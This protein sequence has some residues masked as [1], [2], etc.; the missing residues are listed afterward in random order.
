MDILVFFGALVVAMGFWVLQRLNDTFEMEVK[1]PLSLTG[2]P[3]GVTLTTPLP[4]SVQVTLRDRGTQLMNYM[5]HRIRP[6]TLEFS[7]YDD[8]GATGRGYVP[9]ADVQHAI[10]AQMLTSTVIQRI[11]P[12]T[13]EFFYNRGLHRR[14]PVRFLG[15]AEATERNYLHSITFSPDSVIVYAPALVL[16][17]MTHAYTEETHISNIEEDYVDNLRL[18]PMRGVKYEP[19]VVQMK[20]RVDYYTEKTVSVPIVG[21][22]FPADKVLRA[23]PAQVDVTVRVGA[24]NYNNISADG[25]VLTVSYEDL[26]NHPG[27]RFRPE[28]KSI[29]QGTSSPRLSPPECEYLIEQVESGEMEQHF[30]FAAVDNN[31][32]RIDKWLWASRIFK[33]RTVAAAACK[34][35]QV[36]MKGVALK[37]SRI[38]RVGDIIDVRKSPVTWSF[39]VLQAIERRVGAKLVPEVLENVTSPEQYELL[40]MS[41]ISGF[42]G[43]AKGTGRPTKKDRR[44]LDDFTEDV[45][46]FFGDFDWEDDDEEDDDLLDDEK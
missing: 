6:V 20:A 25:F 24:M 5:R 21:V 2:V 45:P 17:T 40:E 36:T 37:P 39:R 19:D 14:L 33:T 12:D 43:R 34:K 31:E 13:L 22:N 29:P 8:G 10:N 11:T 42:V 38:I 30:R 9:I 4:S 46:Q 1:V 44:T 18:R 23:F 28:V 26:I 7:L 27:D 41:R 15:T 32:A 3:R 35:G 16:D